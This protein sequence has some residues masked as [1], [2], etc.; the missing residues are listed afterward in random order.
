MSAF[1]L[2]VKS[3]RRGLIVGSSICFLVPFLF[4][5]SVD[6]SKFE[7]A[8][9]IHLALLA[10][11]LVVGSLAKFHTHLFKMPYPV[12]VRELAWVPTF[13]LAA[14]WVFGT[15][16]TYVGIVVRSN[17]FETQEYI[18]HWMPFYFTVIKLMPLSFVAFAM[19]DRMIRTFGTR[20][21][22]FAFFFYFGFML[23]RL[24]GFEDLIMGLVW[25]SP[26][27]IALGIFYIYEAPIHIASMEYPV[28]VNLGAVTAFTH[29]PGAPTRAPFVKI[30]ADTLMLLSALPFL[31]WSINFIISIGDPDA[32]VGILGIYMAFMSFSFFYVGREGWRNANAHGFSP[33]KTVLL[34]ALKFSLLFM[35]V[36]WALGAKRGSVASCE[37]CRKHKFIWAAR[38]PHCDDANRGALLSPYGLKLPGTRTKVVA[39]QPK[40]PWSG[41]SSR[42]MFRFMVP[43]QLAIFSMLGH[44]QYQMESVSFHLNDEENRTQSLLDEETLMAY[45][46]GIENVQE[47]L[48]GDDP[49]DLPH[50]YRIDVTPTPKRNGTHYFSVR[51]IWLKWETSTG[52]KERIQERVVEDFPEMDMKVNLEKKK[53]DNW[54]ITSNRFTL[55]KILE[56]NIVMKEWPHGYID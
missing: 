26:F 48:D 21:F 19:V 33:N 41:Y 31:V 27:V 51:V 45:F 13:C 7:S 15:L 37:E 46:E 3:Q 35:P 25:G 11:T 56:Q 53:W 18:E 2:L 8:V 17:F 30:C 22:G 6:P 50:R 4:I 24:P 54:R 20:A 14:L 12:T 32:L 16:G 52:I 39:Q 29:S 36:A 5:F 23:S 44:G 10:A 49:F 43:V 9:A 38:C 40:K 47:W 1:W 34:I 42:A 28:D 55:S